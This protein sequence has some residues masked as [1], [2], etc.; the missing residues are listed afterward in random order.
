MFLISDSF[1]TLI[2]T[3]EHFRKKAKINTAI[4]RWICYDK[5]FTMESIN[6]KKTLFDDDLQDTEFIKKLEEIKLSEKL[7]DVAFGEKVKFVYSYFNKQNVWEESC[8]KTTKSSKKSVDF[9]EAGNT[10]FRNGRHKDALRLY[11]E[12][13]AMAF[14]DS[15]ELSLAFANRSAALFLL[16]NYSACLQDINRSLNLQCPEWVCEKLLKRKKACFVKIEEE[17][18]VLKNLS[19]SSDTVIPR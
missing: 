11:T 5:F 1:V 19:V 7:R 14:P 6:G 12:S 9:R 2:S 10:F 8:L 16:G 18:R 17:N 4:R 15:V 13:V 3:V